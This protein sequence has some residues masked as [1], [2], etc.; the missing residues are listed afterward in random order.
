MY[1]L[2]FYSYGSYKNTIRAVL[3]INDREKIFENV[4]N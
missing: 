4:R 1:D 3:I 2:I